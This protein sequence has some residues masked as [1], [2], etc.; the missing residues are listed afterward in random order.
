MFAL[1]RNK[2]GQPTLEY[3][4]LV[5]VVI[6]ALISMANLLKRHVQGGL[7]SAG[8]DIGDPFSVSDTNSWYRTVTDS[9]ETEL[10]YMEGQLN[11]ISSQNQSR[12]GFEDT[13]SLNQEVWPSQ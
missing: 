9:G 4:I 6:A 7:E 10:R 13:G 5:A 12:E 8:S 2:K 1:L 3:A 11:I